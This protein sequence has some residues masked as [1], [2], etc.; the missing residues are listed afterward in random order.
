MSRS[1]IRN[2]NAL[3]RVLR[4]GGGG[5]GPIIIRKHKDT[6]LVLPQVSIGFRDLRI[7]NLGVEAAHYGSYRRIWSDM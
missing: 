1:I 3:T 5:E 7:V 4:A 6:V 2:E